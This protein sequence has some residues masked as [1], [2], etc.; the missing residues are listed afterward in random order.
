[1]GAP[2]ITGVITGSVTEDSGLVI[3]GNL[4]DAGNGAANT[5]TIASGATY[6]TATINSA[7][8]WSYDLDDTN[9]VVDALDFGE[10]LTD[11]FVVRVTDAFGTDT[12]TITITITGVPCFTAGTLIDTENGP[13]PI[14]D[15][16]PGD[17]VRTQDHGLQPVRWIGRRRV[18]PDALMA[19]EKLWPIRIAAGALGKGVPRRD[20]LVSR[21][22]RMLIRPDMVCELCGEDD[23]LVPALRLLGLPG[24]RLADASGP[25]DYVHLL[26]DRHQIVFAEGAA[27]ESLLLGPQALRMLPPECRQEI[28]AIFPDAALRWPLGVPARHIP[29]RRLQKTLVAWCSAQSVPMM[30]PA[31]R[32]RAAGVSG[33]V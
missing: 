31:A 32:Y 23:V 11:T 14:E 27:S 22:H 30:R 12:Q 21:Q 8:Q 25:V 24:I 17:L 6:G 13:R 28:A 18:G 5:W 20:L 16:Q 19:D 29:D 4:T 3:S 33:A 1:M 7:G 15:L 2:N 9:G 26:F 10:T